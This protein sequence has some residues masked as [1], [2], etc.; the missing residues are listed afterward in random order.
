LNVC[1]I[2]FIWLS[3]HAGDMFKVALLAQKGGVG[4]T[5]L[6]LALAVQAERSKQ[7]AAVVDADPQ[8]TASGWFQ[9]RQER[10]VEAPIVASVPEPSR[11]PAAVKDAQEDGFGWL[12]FDTPAG[13]S[14]QSVA[15]AELADL[16][17]IPCVPSLFNMDAMASTVKLAKRV[18]VPTYFLVNRGRSKAINDDC[19]VSL[20][21]AYGLPAA[22]AHINTRMPIADAEMTGLTLA[23]MQSNDSSIKKGQ[24]EF[25]ALWQWLKKQKGSNGK[26]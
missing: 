10:G 5:T 25:V 13:V 18:G 23:E 8:A 21:S 14:D 19:L 9:R 4:K 12:F 20:T 3:R 6:T 2:D 7:R 24:E 15:A 26:R 11:L 17:L 22:N 16:L 1:L